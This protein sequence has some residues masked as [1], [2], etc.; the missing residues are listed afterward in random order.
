[1]KEINR[2]IGERFSGRP[3]GQIPSTAETPLEK[4]QDLCYEAFEARGRRKVQLA[5]EALEIYPD[6]VDAYVILAEQTGDLDQAL[7]L[8]AEGV[9]AGERTLPIREGE[10][11][12]WG[13]VRTRPFMRAVE[14][15][16]AMC[17]RMGRFEEAIEHYQHLLRLNPNDN[18]GVR[19]PLAGLLLRAG[20]D[21]ALAALLDTYKGDV[22]ATLQFAR[23]LWSFRTKGDTTESRT[24]LRKA[25][26]SNAHVPELLL[27][28][29]PLPPSPDTYS[30][31]D[32]NEAVLCAHELVEGWRRT[33]GALTWLERNAT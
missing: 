3:A 31:G 12:F 27:D 28:E 1:M 14:G 24:H 32:E 19:D 25:I 21:D 4:A 20:D 5:R 10:G 26:R 13:D 8:Y 2:M 16:A 9:K 15:L 23:A 11:Q 22:G 30:F 6:C 33:E 17:A 18:Q 29:D 7:R